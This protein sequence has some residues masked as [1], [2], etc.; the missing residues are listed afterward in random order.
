MKHHFNTA[1]L[2]LRRSWGPAKLLLE[3]LIALQTLI[4]N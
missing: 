4:Q 3:C 2:F 1:V